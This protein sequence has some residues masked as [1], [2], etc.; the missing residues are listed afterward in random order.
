MNMK[1][2]RK[3][4]ICILYW[5]LGLGGV[6][7]KI[8]DIIG[9]LHD[10]Y[11]T[12]VKITIL[13]NQKNKLD[14]KDE[15]FLDSAKRKGIT[16][17]YFPNWQWKRFMF[18]YTLYALGFVFNKKPDILLTFLHKHGVIAGI[19]KLFLFWRKIK[20]IHGQDIAPSESLKEMFADSDELERKWRRL[21][22]FFY[23]F[24]DV[25]ISPS[26]TVKRDLVKNY[27]IRENKIRIINNWIKVPSKPR[28]QKVVYDLIYL[29]RISL[30]KRP[31]MLID[32][33]DDLLKHDKKEVEICII[34]HGELVPKLLKYI[35]EKKLSKYVSF[36][37][38]KKNIF[39][40][41]YRSKMF[42]LP[43]RYEGE[44]IAV[45]EAMACGL[46]V[47]MM[48]YKGAAGL[49][50]DGVNGYICK[51]SKEFVSKIKYLLENSKVRKRMGAQARDFVESKRSHA[52]LESFVSHLIPS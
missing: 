25:I 2:N 18:P 5:D 31:L 35:K 42:I 27:N 16:V 3:L 39:K 51:D 32:V 14:R 19:G 8:A 1:K 38:T 9:Y 17:F 11:G 6:Q 30:Q 49:I 34:G 52:N 26:R 15:L 4:H 22:K 13:L 7:K 40:Y 45:L 48:D 37:G 36:L 33:V 24:L 20:C 47:V 29:G 12:K 50:K 23:P 41:L 43:S 46:P 44:P 28:N 10:K 21:I